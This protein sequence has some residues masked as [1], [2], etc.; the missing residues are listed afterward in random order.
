[1][2]LLKNTDV[3]GKQGGY[4]PKLQHPTEE[5]QESSVSGYIAPVEQAQ[6]VTL[7]QLTGALENM[8]KDQAKVLL[9]QY[10]QPELEQL[11]QD[12]TAEVSAGL[13]RDSAAAQE[14]W[15][16]E[17][18]QALEQAKLQLSAAESQCREAAEFWQEQ[19]A[20]EAQQPEW[21]SFSH[22][23]F[24]QLLF[25][26]ITKVIAVEVVQK[27]YI[28]QLVSQLLAEYHKEQPTCIYV[29]EYHFQQLQQIEKE[30]GSEW[31]LQVKVD[32]KL[33]PGS[34]R[35]E[36]QSGALEQDLLHAL[37]ALKDNLLSLARPED[38]K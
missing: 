30:T 25:R 3:I 11:Q 8:P 10:F 13:Q 33:V 24:V 5:I 36:L 28:Q 15:L 9:R 23:L 26:A 32:A 34:Y 16:A 17:N 37:G 1:M 31:P 29:A 20:K 38:A 18:T 21:E 22:E 6:Q 2:S 27:D 35:I 7:A 12:V 4:V 19:V 14:Q